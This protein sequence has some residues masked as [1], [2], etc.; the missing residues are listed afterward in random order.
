MWGE[1]GNPLVHFCFAFYEIAEHA[2]TVACLTCCCWVC[3]DAQAG[4]RGEKAVINHFWNA[5]KLD[6]KQ[7]M[8]FEAK[9]TCPE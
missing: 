6:C 9:T 5:N 3:N 2:V 4:F 1:E 7:V 8:P